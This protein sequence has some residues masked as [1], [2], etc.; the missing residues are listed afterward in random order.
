MLCQ[1]G[2]IGQGGSEIMLNLLSNGITLSRTN[3]RVLRW[4]K[5]FPAHFLLTPTRKFL[6]ACGFSGIFVVL[7]LSYWIP[8]ISQPLPLNSEVSVRKSPMEILE[9]RKALDAAKVAELEQ[10]WM[11]S[12][13]HWERAVGLNPADPTILKGWIRS[14][15]F[16]PL[17]RKHY[18]RLKN[19]SRQAQQEEAAN[20]RVFGAELVEAFMFYRDYDSARHWIQMI[21]ND[22]ETK[23][24]ERL[25]MQWQL[26]RSLF[27]TKDWQGFSSTISRIPSG[28]SQETTHLPLTQFQTSLIPSPFLSYMKLTSSLN[29]KE[30]L[31][32]ESSP[33][34]A[35]MPKSLPNGF[36]RTGNYFLDT[37]MLRVQLE[38]ARILQDPSSETR[39][40]EMLENQGTL[41]LEDQIPYWKRMLQQD[42]E[43][44]D[45]I[46]YPNLKTSVPFSKKETQYL[47]RF[48][49][50][51]GHLKELQ[52]QTEHWLAAEAETT[53]PELEM[54]LLDLIM[55]QKEW[56]QLQ[57]ATARLRKQGALGSHLEGLTY[58]LDG[59]ANLRTHQLSQAVRCF[60]KAATADY[61]AP[62]VGLHVFGG[63]WKNGRH[64]EA[65][66]LITSLESTMAT[67]PEYWLSRI[68]FHADQDQIWEVRECRISGFNPGETEAF[69]GLSQHISSSGIDPVF[70]SFLNSPYD[71]IELQLKKNRLKEIKQLQSHQHLWSP[72]SVSFDFRMR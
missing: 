44:W 14:L 21:L 28:S 55:D 62:E 36:N 65:L 34:W 47:T 46:I 69:P 61:R 10:D 56:T 52:K 32:S 40:M 26:A 45:K 60:Q 24:S 48:L 66:R 49:K 33:G 6:L 18:L 58:F 54:A 27:W 43:A 19:I 23:Q 71:S 63:L 70:D 59:L 31:R 39:L 30:S 35:E 67:H 16:P 53:D 22:P 9:S 41:L 72:A 64:K 20:H 3:T 13:F 2:Q 51:S 37:D 17:G 4:R 29:S 57:F 15:A 38:L 42:P 68:L 1:S 50:S 7:S 12:R 5:H 8:W 25:K 11:S